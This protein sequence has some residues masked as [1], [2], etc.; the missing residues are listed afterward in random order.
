MA[1]LVVQYLLTKNFKQAIEFAN[2]CAANVVSK[3]GTAIIDFKEIKN[4]LRF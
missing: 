2:I 3:T 4:D 1:G